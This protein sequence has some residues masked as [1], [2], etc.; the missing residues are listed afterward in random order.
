MAGYKI[1][2][3]YDEMAKAAQNFAQHGDQTQQLMQQVKGCV[4]QLKSDWIGAGAKKFQEEMESLV[5]PGINRLANTLKDASDAS[6]KIAD[7]LKQAE[8]SCGALFR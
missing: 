5:F 3:N 1:Q 4:E 8:D 7:A 2:C 6:K